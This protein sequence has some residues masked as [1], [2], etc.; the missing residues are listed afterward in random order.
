MLNQNKCQVMIEKWLNNKSYYSYLLKVKKLQITIHILQ[1]IRRRKH[2]WFCF[3]SLCLTS[4]NDRLFRFL[5]ERNKALLYFFIYVTDHT[6]AFTI[7]AVLL[8]LLQTWVFVNMPTKFT[9]FLNLFWVFIYSLRS[10]T[11]TTATTTKK[12]YKFHR[13]KMR[14]NFKA[15]F[16]SSK[17]L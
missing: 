2:F 9:F 10:E 4:F 3:H 6:A 13:L 14:N 5:M 17:H 1:T 7:A 12:A 16:E 11:T 8:S 15:F